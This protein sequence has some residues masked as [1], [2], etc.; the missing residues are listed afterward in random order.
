MLEF[1]K[2]EAYKAAI[3]LIAYAHR[4]RDEADGVA[5]RLRFTALSIP[6]DIANGDRKE[7]RKEAWSAARE[8]AV[9]S[10]VLLD[11]LKARATVD[12]ETWGSGIALVT[13]LLTGL[14]KGER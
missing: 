13:R 5:E 1:Q 4:L 2:S 12:D 8:N 9:E 6:I 10:A 3:D 11:V 14:R 7:Q